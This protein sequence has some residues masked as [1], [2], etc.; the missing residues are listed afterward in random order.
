MNDISVKFAGK[1]DELFLLN[2]SQLTSEVFNRKYQH[3]EIL[4]ATLD[5]QAVGFLVFDYLWY[6]I[7]FI[8]FIWINVKYR[9]K[10]IG[11]TLLSHLE[12]F[13]L[14]KGNVILFSSSEENAINAQA[15][16]RHMGFKDCGSISGINY[17]NTSEVFFK[18][19]LV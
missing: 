16:H 15:W 19:D 3:D 4:I 8:V 11:K 2:N 9:K 14:N 7:P 18:K 5:G 6:H 1:Q 10:G 17:N 13:L 12:K